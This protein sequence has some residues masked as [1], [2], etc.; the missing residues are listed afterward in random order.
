MPLTAPLTATWYR[1]KRVRRYNKENS[2]SVTEHV[3]S[4]QKIHCQPLDTY[5]EEK[6]ERRLSQI[7]ENVAFCGVE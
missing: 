5:I 6:E 4:S 7:Q 2:S 1:G 3:S